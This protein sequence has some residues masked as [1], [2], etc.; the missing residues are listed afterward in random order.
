MSHLRS[1]IERLLI[2][3]QN[4]LENHVK[5]M[6]RES[7]EQAAMLFDAT[8]K[9]ED[10]VPITC[11]MVL[12]EDL[13]DCGGLHKH[14]P[15]TGYEVRGLRVV[16]L[17]WPNGFSRCIGKLWFDPGKASEARKAA[18]AAKEAK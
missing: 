10:G 1:E 8:P 6:A 7:L 15:I 14:E 18:Q 11:G 9:T 17:Y 5:A 4:G 2:A 12:W 16:T 13:G 3:Y